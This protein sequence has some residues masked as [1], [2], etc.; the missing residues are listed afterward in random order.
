MRK[1][2]L[3]YEGMIVKSSFRA[4]WV[5]VITS[6]APLPYQNS[7]SYRCEVKLI[8]TPSGALQRKGAKMTLSSAWLTEA[9][10]SDEKLQQAKIKKLL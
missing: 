1:K 8:L 10:L 9:K 3:P 4:A 5:G 2:L 6:I 7:D